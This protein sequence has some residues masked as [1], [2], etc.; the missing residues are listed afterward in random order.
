VAGVNVG[1]CGEA[2]RVLVGVVVFCG[3]ICVFCFWRLLWR[4]NWGEAQRAQRA[5]SGTWNKFKTMC[6]DWK[7]GIGNCLCELLLFKCTCVRIP[8]SFLWTILRAD[9]FW[10]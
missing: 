5:E 8:V 9:A 3:R 10:T 7:R 6:R 4:G 1:R 2:V